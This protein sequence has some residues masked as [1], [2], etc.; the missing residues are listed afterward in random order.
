MIADLIRAFAANWLAAIG[1]FIAAFI[2]P[3]G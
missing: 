3:W 1:G 2:C